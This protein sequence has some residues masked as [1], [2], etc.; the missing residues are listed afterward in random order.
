MPISDA[1]AGQGL[2]SDG[3]QMFMVGGTNPS[4]L[5]RLSAGSPQSISA[6][7]APIAVNAPPVIAAPSSVLVQ[8]GL[9]SPVTG[10]S[11][12]DADAVSANETITATLVD[13]NG[14]LSADTGAVNGGGTISGAGSTSLSISGTLAQ[15]NADL[16][17]LTDQ[18]SSLSSDIISLNASDSRGGNAVPQTISVAETMSGQPCYCP[19]TLIRTAHGQEADRGLKGRRQDQDRLRPT[20]ANQMDR[21]A[22]LWP[23][24]HHGAQRTSAGL[25][26]GRRAR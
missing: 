11:I 22:Q 2:I 8:Q 9:A 15:V 3:A 13:T 14:L 24:F 21:T 12:S 25:H 1:Y 16:T 7:S 10:V 6:T 19:G 4:A 17:T 5:E 23:P 26:Q 18:D 20:A